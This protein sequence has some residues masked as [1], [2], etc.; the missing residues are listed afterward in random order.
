MH[1]LVL[2]MLFQ[3]WN[4]YQCYPITN[5]IGQFMQCKSH[6]DQ[7]SCLKI[8][9]CAFRQCCIS[10]KKEFMGECGDLHEQRPELCY[11]YNNKLQKQFNN[12]TEYC[13]WDCIDNSYSYH[14]EDVYEKNYDD[15]LILSVELISA[16][17]L[18]VILCTL[19]CGRFFIGIWYLLY[20]KVCL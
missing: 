5:K 9:G 8:K 1:H 16:I 2:L 6:F 7:E 3:L 18:L 19:S 12:D 13:I 4:S 14:F 20:A 17:G 10:I 15:L 11:Q